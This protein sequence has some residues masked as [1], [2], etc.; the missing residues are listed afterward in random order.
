MTV[1]DCHPR[2]CDI[3]GNFCLGFEAICQDCQQGGSPCQVD[4]HG[5]F[6][7]EFDRC[8]AGIDECIQKVD[9]AQQK[10]MR[11]RAAE[12]DLLAQLEIVHNLVQRF[13]ANGSHTLL[14]STIDCGRVAHLSASLM[15]LRLTEANASDQRYGKC[16]HMVESLTQLVTSDCGMQDEFAKELI[17]AQSGKLI[18]RVRSLM[19]EEKVAKEC[20]ATDQAPCGASSTR[21]SRSTFLSGISGQCDNA[22]DYSDWDGEDSEEMNTFEA[23]E[24]FRNNA[25]RLFDELD[26]DRDGRLSQAEV[27]NAASGLRGLLRACRIHK[28]RH[29]I[30]IF[31]E[32]TI[33]NGGAIEFDEFVSYILDARHK[34]FMAHPKQVDEAKVR[35]VFDIM[36]RDKDGAISRQELE[37][38]YAGILIEAG[39]AVDSKRVSQW[40]ARH[41]KKHD[42]DCSGTLDLNEF[43]ELLCHSGTLSPMLD[44]TFEVEL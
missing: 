1:N 24:L 42:A 18:T 14:R 21:S 15:S 23:D 17:I 40:V 6:S 41:F 16:Q 34:S 22:E 38:A 28:R 27:L 26:T 5:Q 30:K 33:D 7:R 10:A 32:A 2:I 12:S 19:H 11:L 9:A 25:R 39:E 31:E 20:S 8:L 36:D 13:R 35:R 43:K 3:C 44:F 37:L 4:V 29:V